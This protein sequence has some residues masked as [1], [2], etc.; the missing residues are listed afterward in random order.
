MSARAR[1]ASVALGMVAAISLCG[2]AS[3]SEGVV[4]CY[5]IGQSIRRSLPVCE[6]YTLSVSSKEDR[7]LPAGLPT[8]RVVD[9]SS[10]SRLDVYFQILYSR[11]HFERDFELFKGS[12]AA[13]FILRDESETIIQTKDVERSLVA[14]SYNESVSSRHDAFLQT[15][16]LPSGKYT[17]EIIV[18]D[19]GSDLRYRRR[20][21]VEVKNFSKE[22][23]CASDYLLY[24]SSHRED[25]E[26]LLRPIFLSGLSFVKDSL[27]IFQEMYNVQ[28]GDTVRL[29][30]SYTCTKRE[31]TDDTKP[32]SMYPPYKLK[33]PQ[34]TRPLDS[35]YYSHDSVF[36]SS[37]SGSVQVFQYFPKP[38]QGVTAMTRK[39]FLSRNGNIDSSVNTMKIPVYGFSFPQL[40]TIDE[41]IA[42]V[43]YIA[44]Q[45]ELDSIR[46][47]ATSSERSVRLNRFWQ[48][49]GGAVRQQEFYNRI[50]EANELF[51]SC[52]EGW[53][54]AMGI[55]YIVCG[56]PDYVECQGSINEVWYYSLGSNRGLAIPFRQNLESE[57]GRYYEIV[58]FSVN[59]YLWQQFVERWRR[60]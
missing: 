1:V 30:F 60:K 51:S 58:P 53:K 47:G 38:A 31:G 3:S 10:R 37:T 4:D 54:T 17:L 25:K 33:L 43:S 56:P 55:T 28:R 39:I 41:E 59:D 21:K 34:C 8:H 29:S 2:C 46:A 12:Y 27:G 52:V 44:H 35:I 16:L 40:S 20:Q 22:N 15:F 48:E 26:I 32:V 23:F 18:L 50:E 11:I 49:H 14:R 24:E 19:N 6:T 45:E 7:R 36:V 13:S 9:D 42:A 57:M 5:Y